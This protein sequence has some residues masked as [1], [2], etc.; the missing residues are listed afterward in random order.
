MVQSSL[1]VPGNSSASTSQKR[2][3]ENVDADHPATEEVGPLRIILFKKH[4][5]HFLFL[6]CYKDQKTSIR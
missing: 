1:I 6:F 5:A 3:T 4:Q 2:S